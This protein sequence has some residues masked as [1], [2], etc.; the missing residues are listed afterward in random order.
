MSLSGIR[1]FVHVLRGSLYTRLYK[2]S[3]VYKQST[4]YKAYM[5]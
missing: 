3:N 5:L 4:L 2:Y 1:G